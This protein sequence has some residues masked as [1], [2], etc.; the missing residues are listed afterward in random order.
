MLVLDGLLGEKHSMIMLL[1]LTN[2]SLP[3]TETVQCVV[4]MVTD[5][6]TWLKK[7]AYVLKIL[8]SR[9]GAK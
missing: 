5:S 7:K 8:T 6:Q 2:C 3:L 4:G 1:S 9:L